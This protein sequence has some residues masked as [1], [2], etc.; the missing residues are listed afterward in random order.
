MVNFTSI[1]LSAVAALAVFTQLAT[2][3]TLSITTTEAGTLQSLVGD[4]VTMYSTQSIS[5]SGP[6]NGTDLLC[7]RRMTGVDSVRL[8]ITG[9]KLTS[10]DLSGANIVAGGF[11]YLNYEAKDNELGDYVFYQ[12]TKLKEIKMPQSITRIGSS[13]FQQTDLDSADIPEGVK[14]IGISA[15]NMIYSLKEVSLP[16]TLDT[17]MNSAFSGC[18]ELE[19]VKFHPNAPIATIRSM[20]F[21]ST[22]KLTTLEL[23]N[24]IKEIGLYAFY[25]SGLTSLTLPS[26]ITTLGA[27]AFV[28]CASLATLGELP[29]S[30]TSIGA[31]AF[32]GTKLTAISVASDNPIYHSEGGLLYETAKNMIVVYPAGSEATAFEIPASVDSIAEGAFYGASSLASLTFAGSPGVA[33]GVFNQCTGLATLNF[34]ATTPPTFRAATLN[35]VADTVTAYVPEGTEDAYEAALANV[36]NKVVIVNRP[37][38][39][40]SATSSSTATEVARYNLSG[41][42]LATP[43]KGINIVKYSD[44]TTRK[45]VV[46]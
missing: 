7:L 34:L 17:L 20:A 1:K 45:E 38:S 14:Y 30:L 37:T 3:Q 32:Q 6:I 35:N 26:S 42:K 33:A 39:I 31:K 13:A 41:Q 27:S 5:V 12:S 40:A 46:K 11:Y 29:A 2:A 23:S 24:S 8:G 4:S 18:S 22:P 36:S 10:I 9:G 43:T 28:G 16:S 19:I 25:N 44:G 21:M 15:F